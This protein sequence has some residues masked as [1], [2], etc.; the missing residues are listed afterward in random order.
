MFGYIVCC[1]MMVDDSELNYIYS[2]LINHRGKPGIN[3]LLICPSVQH[4][5][6]RH[7]DVV[8]DLS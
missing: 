4:L 2:P 3:G 5:S 1:M 8:K 6:N 7:N